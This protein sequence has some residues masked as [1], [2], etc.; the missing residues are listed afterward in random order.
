MPRFAGET[1]VQ[2]LKGLLRSSLTVI[3]VLKTVTDR[4]PFLRKML[5]GLPGIEQEIR[6]A[7]DE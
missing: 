5:P 7:L 2:H 6:D 1:E 4:D 3:E